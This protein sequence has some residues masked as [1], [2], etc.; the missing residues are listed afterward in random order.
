MLY[1]TQGNHSP[2]AA[3]RRLCRI[4]YFCLLALALTSSETLAQNTANPETAVQA[5]EVSA[6]VDK[7]E[8][9]VGDAL[10]LTVTVDADSALR[11]TPLSLDTK[12][13]DFE[14][15][16]VDRPVPATLKDGRKRYQTRIK[17]W[18]LETGQHEIPSVTIHYA[19]NS[20][21]EDSL[22]TGAVTVSVSSL[23]DEKSDSAA[24]KP[25]REPLADPLGL[26]KSFFQ[27][28]LF[29]GLLIGFVILVSALVWWLVL[30][31]RK[32]D[33]EWV[34]PR[35]AWE[36]ALDRLAN[37]QNQPYLVQGLFK[38]YYSELTDTLRDYLGEE[39]QHQTLDMTSAELLAFLENDS[40]TVVFKPQI[41][42][43]L[44]QADMVKFAKATPSPERPAQ[45]FESV[46]SVIQS[47]RD[48]LAERRRAE[49]ERLRALA[50]Q[51]SDR[52]ADGN[53]DSHNNPAAD[54]QPDENGTS[55]LKEQ[56]APIREAK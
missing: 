16:S 28:P 49:E 26:N 9:F 22:Q 7:V 37:L 43:V 48:G 27:T 35:P 21:V 11:I 3:G 31:K 32:E 25:I 5:P 13:G 10:S 23:L 54:T 47:I 33:E 8:A 46:Y 56:I 15:Q 24:I 1:L 39:L 36:K 55:A 18:A 12:L 44:T 30:R 17:L 42:A 52:S 2:F 14:I 53:S 45:D 29:W 6:T 19:D 20:G 38:E 50:N 4:L 34:D 41:S 51:K 40:L